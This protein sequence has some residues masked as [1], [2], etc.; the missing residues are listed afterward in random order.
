MEQNV[1]YENKNTLMCMSKKNVNS[2]LTSKVQTAKR[3]SNKF[4]EYEII[5]DRP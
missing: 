5:S 4:L 2:R 3:C 1:L